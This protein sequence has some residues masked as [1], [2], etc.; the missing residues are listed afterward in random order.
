MGLLKSTEN[1]VRCG[2]CNSEFDINKND[3]CPMCG[4]GSKNSKASAQEHTTPQSTTRNYLSAPN[5]LKIARRSGNLIPHKGSK[6]LWGM[7]NSFFPGKAVSRILGNMMLEKSTAWTSLD[8]L[9]KKSSEVIEATGMAG[10]RGFPKDP[11]SESAMGRL[12]YH[13]IG[14]F[15]DMGLFEVRV[16]DGQKES[17]TN[18][19]W[20]NVEITLTYE[21]LEFA[22]LRNRVFDNSEDEQILTEEERNWFLNHLKRISKEGF[23]EYDILKGVFEFLKAGHNGKEE[24][25]GW[26]AH[27]KDFLDNVKSW[28]RKSKDA[29]AFKNQVENLAIT[30]AAGKIALLRELGIIK[31]QRNNYSIV[32]ELK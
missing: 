24:L 19:S 3:G 1:R 16:K 22:K 25:R 28:S 14:S 29:V 10:L 7:V 18:E 30:F 26:F 15:V 13:F 11:D 12:V 6:E 21:G 8:D 5:T 27:N 2:Q 9:A 20:K 23:H 17:W 4:F 32:G 31:N